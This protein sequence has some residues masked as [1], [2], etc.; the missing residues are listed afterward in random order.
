MQNHKLY[1]TCCIDL[2]VDSGKLKWQIISLFLNHFYNLEKSPRSTTDVLFLVC[3]SL[4]AGRRL[5]THNSTKTFG[6][7]CTIDSMLWLTYKVTYCGFFVIDHVLVSFVTI[8][9][10]GAIFSLHQKPFGGRFHPDLLGDLEHSPRPSSC[11]TGGLL[12]REG[13]GRKGKG[14][15]WEGR[16]KE[17]TANER[18]EKGRE[19]RGRMG[20]RRGRGDAPHP[21]A[22]S[23]IRP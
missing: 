6:S 20:G 13:E 12:L 14:I 1:N 11:K 23:W 16:G 22:N 2:A 21:N 5:S 19:G 9:T 17:G 8:A 15:G 7:N 3:L 10:S 4:C 18:R